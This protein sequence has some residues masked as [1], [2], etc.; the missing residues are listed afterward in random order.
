MFF[1]VNKPGKEK[2]VEGGNS[3]LGQTVGRC[4]GFVLMLT[5]LGTPGKSTSDVKCSWMSKEC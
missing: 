3:E 2:G 5:H 1:S 4:P